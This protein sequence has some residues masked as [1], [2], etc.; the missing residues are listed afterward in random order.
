MEIVHKL[1][2]GESI[3]L[4]NQSLVKRNKE[5][6]LE[7]ESLRH[8]VEELEEELKRRELLHTNDSNLVEEDTQNVW[9]EPTFMAVAEIENLLKIT[10]GQM[11]GWRQRKQLPKVLA[12]DETTYRLNHTGTGTGK[13]VKKPWFVEPHVNP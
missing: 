3:D 12:V 13:K 7:L 2:E 11:E 1:D 10:R 5:L 8:K 9:G 6:E 4:E